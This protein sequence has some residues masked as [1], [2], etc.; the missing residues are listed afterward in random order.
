MKTVLTIFGLIL[1]TSLFSSCM[2]SQQNENSDSDKAVITYS[3]DKS[4]SDASLK[5]SVEDVPESSYDFDLLPYDFNALEPV[6]DTKTMK[7]H[8]DKH[9]KGYYKKFLKAIKLTG[10]YG[11]DIIEIFSQI[12]NY[13]SG[14]RNN[15]GGY[16]NHWLFWHS[17]SPEKNQEPSGKIK[18]AIEESFGS[19]NSF[20]ESF[21]QAASKQ[22]GSGWAWL[23]VT[24]SG[25]LMVTNTSNQDNPLMDLVDQNGYP[26]LALDVWEHAYYVKYQNKRTSYIENFWKII[27]WAKVNERYQ[28]AINQKAFIP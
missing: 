25:K 3:K 9:H 15:A 22:F 6:I 1:I 19:L 8:Y 27:D 21:N 28:D 23:I 14:V 18:M 26:I 13:S 12:S 4:E 10:D 7:L 17:L 24:E 20:Q 11:T 16:Y 2:N 5:P